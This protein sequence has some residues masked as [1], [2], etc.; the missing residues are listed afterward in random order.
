MNATFLKQFLEMSE[1]IRELYDVVGEIAPLDTS[2]A[3]R[4]KQLADT[5]AALTQAESELVGARLSKEAALADAAALLEQT[6]AEVKAV[7][8]AA[9]SEAKALVDAASKPVKDKA[10]QLKA[11]QGDHDAACDSHYKQLL[12]L[13]AEVEEEEKLLAKI[14]AAIAKLTQA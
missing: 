6:Q 8:A 1:H 12:S 9:K 5:G 4:K 11:L 7:K 2:I 3:L 14:K 10:D 13:R